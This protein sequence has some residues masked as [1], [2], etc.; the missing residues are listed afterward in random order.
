MFRKLSMYKLKCY[1]FARVEIKKALRENE[2]K[3]YERMNIS[4]TSGLCS[5]H[6]LGVEQKLYNELNHGIY[7]QWPI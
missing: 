7:G 1:N 4:L 5:Q 2:Y 3:P 6:S